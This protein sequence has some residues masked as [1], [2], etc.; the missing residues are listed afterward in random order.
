MKLTA[1]QRAL[2]VFANTAY[3]LGMKRLAH[4]FGEK[5]NYAVTNDP[6]FIEFCND[7]FKTSD[8]R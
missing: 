4:Y 6:R 8:E 7:F 2:L 3:R 1:K 5:Y